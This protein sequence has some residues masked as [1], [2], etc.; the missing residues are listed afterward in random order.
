MKSLFSHSFYSLLSG[1][2]YL[3]IFNAKRIFCFTSPVRSSYTLDP[4]HPI[5]SLPSQLLSH[6]LSVFHKIMLKSLSHPHIK[7]LGSEEHIS[8]F[9]NAERATCFFIPPPDIIR[10]TPSIGTP[11]D[12]YYT[13]APNPL[14]SLLPF[15]IL[16]PRTLSPHSLPCPPTTSF[17]VRYFLVHSS[18]RTG[19]GTLD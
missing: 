8:S 14:P 3:L 18:I 15:P 17:F 7:T 2:A 12:T 13:S 1:S 10:Y 19:C 6:L 9:S 16:F 5:Y 4:Y 11:L